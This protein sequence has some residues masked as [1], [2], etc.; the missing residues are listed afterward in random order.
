MRKNDQR[1]VALYFW[2]D[3][4]LLSVALFYVGVIHGRALDELGVSIASQAIFAWVSISALVRLYSSDLHAGY[5]PLQFTYLKTFFVFLGVE[6]SI[7]ALVGPDTVFYWLASVCAVFIA[8]ISAK[9]IVLNEVVKRAR[10]LGRNKRKILVVGD[11]CRA[12]EATKHIWGNAHFGLS[13]DSAPSPDEAIKKIKRNHYDEV[14]I[15][16]KKDDDSVL[17]SIVDVCDSSGIRVNYIPSFTVGSNSI[18]ALSSVAGLE[19]LSIRSYALDNIYAAAIK[20]MFDVVSSV[21]AIVFFLPLLLAVALLIKLESQGPVFYCPER[22]GRNGNRFKVFKFRSMYVMQ[23]PNHASKS[24]QKNDPRITKV[25][26]VLRK[27]SLDE[28]PQFINVLLGEMSV[29][30]P[31]P[32][33]PYLDE[34]MQGCVKNYSLRQYVKPGITG[35]AQVSGWRGPTDTAEQREQRTLHDLWYLQNWSLYLDLKIVFLTVFDRKVYA[36][37]F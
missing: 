12:V 23:D 34:L 1:L 14:L 30:G 15:S 29:V 37:A 11:S 27:T 35:W 3:L 9:N 26:Q 6:L 4:L 5:I 28:F 25:G 8:L 33:R 36:S 13:V 2:S 10:K 18:M 31:R 16:L 17:A 20:R 7:S 19:S 32:H 22:V 24:T 21:F